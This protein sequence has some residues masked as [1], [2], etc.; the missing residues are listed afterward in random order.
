[1]S[2]VQNPP[3]NPPVPPSP[4]QESKEPDWLPARLEQAK[5]SAEAKLLEAIGTADV[6]SA[7]KAIATAKAAEEANKTAEQRAADLQAQLT[8]KTAAHDLLDATAKAQAGHMMGVLSPEQQ[9]LV[10]SLAGD[11]PAKQLSTITALAPTWAKQEPVKPV[12]SMPVGG[13]SSDP[14]SPPEHRSQHASL[15]ATGNPFAAAAYGL[16]HPEVFEPRKS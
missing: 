11:D 16:A 1:M 6:D 5:R 14:T 12:S 2:E 8:A 7:K 9:A 3:V 4:T 15:K 10:K 13:P